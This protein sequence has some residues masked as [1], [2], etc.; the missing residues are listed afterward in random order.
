MADLPVPR[1]TF[2]DLA[3][4]DFLISFH[5]Y[6]GKPRHFLKLPSVARAAVRSHE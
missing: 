3:A 4:K 2:P 1:S 5:Q 6:S